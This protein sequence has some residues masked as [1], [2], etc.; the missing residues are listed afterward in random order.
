[1]LPRIFRMY[2]VDQKDKNIFRKEKFCIL[3]LFLLSEVF[4]CVI[5][6]L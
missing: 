5:R 6:K 2:T 4:V 1:M 3:V